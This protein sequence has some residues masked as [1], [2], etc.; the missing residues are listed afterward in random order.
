MQAVEDANCGGD[1][2]LQRAKIIDVV[3]DLHEQR[4]LSSMFG[5]LRQLE[6]GDD[7]FFKVRDG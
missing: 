4:R 1:G 2:A 6:K 3:E 5:H 7:P